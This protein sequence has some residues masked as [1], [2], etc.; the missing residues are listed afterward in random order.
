MQDIENQLFYYT[1]LLSEDDI[2]DPIV[3][4]EKL[5]PFGEADEAV[6]AGVS[7]N[8]LSDAEYSVPPI[9]EFLSPAPIDFVAGLDQESEI[10]LAD[11]SYNLSQDFGEQDVVKETVGETLFPT[12]EGGSSSQFPK[13]LLPT[14]NQGFPNEE[15]E[16]SGP[17][18]RTLTANT[19]QDFTST[20]N[21][22]VHIHNEIPSINIEFSGTIDNHVDVEALLRDI[23]KRLKEEIASG[24]DF[25]YSF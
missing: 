5:L 16:P 17:D 8:N 19:V 21:S 22:Q 11:V 23:Q 2:D 15:N 3:F 9:A 20:A 6:F 14:D 1:P 25:A 10:R 24:S 4:T 12:L 7:V 13:A 18:L